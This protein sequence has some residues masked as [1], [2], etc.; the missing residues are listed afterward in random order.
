MN[1]EKDFEDF[2][3]DTNSILLLIGLAVIDKWL[4]F[5][6]LILFLLKKIIQQIK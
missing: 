4:G 5:I 6:F 2:A 1:D 3:D